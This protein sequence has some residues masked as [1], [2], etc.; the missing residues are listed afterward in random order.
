MITISYPKVQ[1]ATPEPALVKR[2][3]A[4]SVPKLEAALASKSAARTK[5]KASAKPK[6]SGS[7][8]AEYGRRGGRVRGI[9]ASPAA[10]AAA[11]TN[12]ARGGRP[13]KAGS[14]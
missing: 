11:Q 7:R 9:K 2:E 6:A 13:R 10:A 1:A 5:P 12:G 8:W 14:R 4:A 3:V